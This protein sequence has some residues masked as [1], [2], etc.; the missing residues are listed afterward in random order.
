MESTIF[1]MDSIPSNEELKWSSKLIWKIGDLLAYG[2]FGEIY[3]ASKAD[4]HVV[5]KAVS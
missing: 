2:S 1:F 4:E 5:I 3:N